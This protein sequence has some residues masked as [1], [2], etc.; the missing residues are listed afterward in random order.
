MVSTSFATAGGTLAAG[1][2]SRFSPTAGKEGKWV[3]R[4]V[5]VTPDGE[6]RECSRTEHP[7][8][9]HA[10]LGGFGYFG[11][12]TEIT[13]D[14]LDVGKPVRIKT[15]V[16]RRPDTRELHS[17]LLA[18]DRPEATRTTYSVFAITNDRVRTMYC[19][20][21]YSNDEKLS[22]MMPHRP[23]LHSR[24]LTELLVQWLPA[25]GQLFWNYAY[26][27]YIRM[28]DTYVD[29]THG[30]MFFMDGNVRA[31]ALGKKLGMRFRAIQQTFVIPL[32]EARL[33]D[34][35]SACVRTMKEAGTPPAMIDALCLPE[36]EGFLL[37]STRAL[38][39]YAVSIAF[40]SLNDEKIARVTRCLEEL[41]NICGAMGGRVHLTKNVL[42]RPDDVRAMYAGVLESFF[43]VKAKYD[44][45]AIVSSGFIEELFLRREKTA[46]EPR[47]PASRTHAGAPAVH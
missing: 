44:P 32:D 33:N 18:P 8:L 13:Y 43:A 12:V 10:A 42:A 6:V 41:S 26:D 38:P 37:S 17:S 27:V 40:E 19:H 3:A 1:C 9:F 45:H 20:S 24:V 14:L 23:E 7:D 4:F 25:V 2:M 47:V 35:I 15:V 22:P 28:N 39:G 16:T 36:D 29:A 46:A 30:Y 11:A 5:M 34:F 21:Q 31:K